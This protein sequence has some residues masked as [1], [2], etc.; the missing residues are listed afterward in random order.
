MRTSQTP[1]K[2]LSPYGK[3]VGRLENR[4]QQTEQA[5]FPRNGGVIFAALP[6]WDIQALLIRSFLISEA[7]TAGR[8]N[9]CEVAVFLRSARFR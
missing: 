8:A 6:T 5:Y 7:H 2:G 3:G 1:G 4:N 9:G